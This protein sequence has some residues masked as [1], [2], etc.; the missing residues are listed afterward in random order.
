M[1][2]WDKSTNFTVEIQFL[3]TLQKL[4]TSLGSGRKQRESEAP[5]GI[6]DT[7][8][9]LPA[10]S[11][12]GHCSRGNEAPVTDGRLCLGLSRSQALAQSNA[13]TVTLCETGTLAFPM[14]QHPPAM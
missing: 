6:R 13:P 11:G 12:L 9:T 3:Q 7:F 5:A 14:S 1:C 4:Q 2:L 10:P 8:K